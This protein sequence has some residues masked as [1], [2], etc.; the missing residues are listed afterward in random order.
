MIRRG[1][2]FVVF[3]L[4]FSCQ[5]IDKASMPKNLLEED[6]MVEIL[7]DIA[8]I[9]AAKNSNRNILEENNISPEA[10]IL[11]KHGVDSVVFA[12]NHIW[13]SNHIEQYVAIFKNVKANLNAE[14][15]KYEKLKKQE[16]SIRKAEDSI[17]KIKDTL[18]IKKEKMFQ[19]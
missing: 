10:F 18:T 1:L 6:H 15:V 19:K 4:I 3:L 5:S 12:E 13:Y 17:K 7:T 8:F 11:R 2:Y 16:D 14:E 9:K